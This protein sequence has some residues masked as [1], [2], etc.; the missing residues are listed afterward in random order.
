HD[1]VVLPSE[2]PLAGVDAT[3]HAPARGSPDGRVVMV[4]PV[5]VQAVVRVVTDRDEAAPRAGDDGVH[6]LAEVAP[7][8]GAVAAGAPTDVLP[9]PAGETPDER[10]LARPLRIVGRPDG[11]DRD[12]RR[13]SARDTVEHAVAGAERAPEHAPP[14][15]G[16]VVEPRGGEDLRPQAIPADGHGVAARPR[17]DAG[18][19]LEAAATEGR[20]I[21]ARPAQARRPA[22]L[23]GPRP[24]R[25]AGRGS[26]RTATTAGEHDRQH[27]GNGSDG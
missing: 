19:R 7:V 5:L 20:H 10:V 8:G 24:S 12:D 26:S 18:H 16:R 4:L 17:R 13:A 21:V 15:P 1:L 27:A 9:R 2:R 22:A 23:D 25:I 14:D 3:P 11:A 6:R